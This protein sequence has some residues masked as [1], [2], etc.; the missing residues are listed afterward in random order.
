MCL[1]RAGRSPSGGCRQGGAAPLLHLRL[2]QAP[3]ALKTLQCHVV[4][5]IKLR[6]GYYVVHIKSGL[7]GVFFLCKL[8][9]LTMF[10][11]SSTGARNTE[12]QQELIA[13]ILSM[14]DL[15]GDLDVYA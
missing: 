3:S 13:M 6:S 9:M 5:L 8:T 12:E 14:Q 4:A 10:C 15:Q 11:Y 1:S 2:I 7:A